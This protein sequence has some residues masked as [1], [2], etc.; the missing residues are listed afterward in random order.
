MFKM[1]EVKLSTFE[2]NVRK[3]VLL[4]HLSDWTNPAIN[5]NNIPMI[6]EAEINLRMC[7]ERL[8]RLKH[9]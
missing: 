9:G 1:R 4:K 7:E 2:R 6:V 8:R 3:E 5:K